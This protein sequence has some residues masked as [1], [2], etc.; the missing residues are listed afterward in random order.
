MSDP[1]NMEAL[2]IRDDQQ[3][4]LMISEDTGRDSD[5]PVAV[6]LFTPDMR[7]LMEHYHIELSVEHASKL[8]EWLGRFLRTRGT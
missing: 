5:E 7:K 8:H 4:N 1:W 3:Y 6:L 2:K